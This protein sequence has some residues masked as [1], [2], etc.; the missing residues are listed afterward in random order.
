MTQLARLD[1]RFSAPGNARIEITRGNFGFT[2]H[3]IHLI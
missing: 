1:V 2:V 3:L